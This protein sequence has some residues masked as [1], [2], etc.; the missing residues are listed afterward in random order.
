LLSF[1]HSR[2]ALDEWDA[3]DL[4]AAD[5]RLVDEAI[6]RALEAVC[7]PR[8]VCLPSAA[9]WAKFQREIDRGFAHCPTRSAAHWAK[10]LREMVK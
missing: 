5:L 9:H 8:I 4:W 10:F 2:A 7:A 3:R 6:T 1:I